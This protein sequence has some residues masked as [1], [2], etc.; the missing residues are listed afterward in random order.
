MHATFLGTSGYHPSEARHTTGLAL[1]AANTLIDAGT[2]TFR[3]PAVMGAEVGDA[4]ELDVFLSHAHLDHVSGLTYFIVWMEQKRFGR[5][6]V[7][8][9]PEVHEAVD[10]HLFSERIFPVRIGYERHEM[11]PGDAATLLDGSRMTTRPQPHRGVTFGYRIQ[12]AAGGSL[13]FCTD[14]TANPDDAASVDFVRG[15]NVLIHECH[16]AD[17]EARFDEPTGHSS[18]TKVATLAKNAGVGRLILTHINPYY[19]PERPLDVESVR[20]VFGETVVAEDGM[21]VGF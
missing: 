17:S 13:C 10:R 5:V 2:G 12:T 8:A 1:P 20:D 4:R 3:L 6:R 18:L 9:E 7:F 21:T 11:R 14:T 16:F 15:C 19:D